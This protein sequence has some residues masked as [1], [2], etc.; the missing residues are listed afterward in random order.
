[1]KKLII[2]C[3]LFSTCSIFGQ[4]AFSDCV[5]ACLNNTALVE[6][7]SPNAIAEIELA[8]TGN[9]AVYTVYLSEKAI[10]P[11]KKIEFKVGIRDAAT[12]TIWSYS[13]QIYEEVAVAEILKN[14][15][16]GDAILL[17][18]VDKAYAFPHNEI[19]VK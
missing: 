2:C 18:T 5:A 19:L 11:K 1:M 6:S 14:C 17:L 7:Y 10:T 16:K 15:N 4:S 3:L 12:Q 9:L 8:A 13:E